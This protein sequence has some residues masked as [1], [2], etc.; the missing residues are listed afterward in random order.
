MGKRGP[1]P[2]TRPSGRKKGTPNKLTRDIKA[3]LEK[4]FDQAGGADYLFDVSQEDKRTFC[5]LL[6]KILPTT[7]AS[8]PENPLI[9]N[10]IEIELVS[11]K[12]KDS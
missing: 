8:D 6:G 4:A 7:H 1:K 10:K 2:G 5:T 11:A 9:P 12:N 3:A